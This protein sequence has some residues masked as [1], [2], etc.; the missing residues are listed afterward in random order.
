[1]IPKA[2]EICIDRTRRGPATAT[3]EVSALA[4]GH[5]GYIHTRI[6]TYIP[7]LLHTYPP[8]TF[9]HIHERVRAEARTRTKRTDRQTDRQRKRQNGSERKLCLC[10]THIHRRVGAEARTRT[11]RAADSL[12]QIARQGRRH[13]RRHVAV[14]R[15]ATGPGPEGGRA[16]KPSRSLQTCMCVC[17]CVCAPRAVREKRVAKMIIMVISINKAQ[18][19]ASLSSCVCLSWI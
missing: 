15:G 11:K 3:R 2:H 5:S 9:I 19:L 16:Q 13:R 1:M 4:K 8:P 7:H 17:V 12:A 14:G 18:R 10:Y 6:H